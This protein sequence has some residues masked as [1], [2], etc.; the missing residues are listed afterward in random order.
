MLEMSLQFICYDDRLSEW[1]ECKLDKGE[2]CFTMHTCCNTNKEFCCRIKRS[3]AKAAERW[4]T[5]NSTQQ[6]DSA[7]VIWRI[8]NYKWQH[9]LLE[10][11]CRK[12]ACC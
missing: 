11:E 10:L 3:K 4:V 7:E 6:I 5:H 2:N 12:E 9:S 1:F 8:G